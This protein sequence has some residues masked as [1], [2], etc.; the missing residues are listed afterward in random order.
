VGELLQTPLK[1]LFIDSSTLSLVFCAAI[2][3]SLLLLAVT[4][5]AQVR[6]KTQQLAMFSYCASCEYKRDG[7]SI[8]KPDVDYPFNDRR[9]L[10]ICFIGAYYS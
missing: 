2:P 3:L 5:T 10:S 6:L 1:S 7:G 4:L 9:A 8:D